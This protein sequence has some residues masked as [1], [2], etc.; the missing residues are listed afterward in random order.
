LSI[1][2]INPDGML[3]SPAFSQAIAVDPG[4]KLIFIGGQDGVDESGRVVADDLAGQTR[5]TLRNMRT[6]CETAGGKLEDIFK[7]TIF[8]VEGQDPRVGFGVFQE[9]WDR[10]APP[11]II[12]AAFV[13][14]LGVAG[15]LVEIEA[16][17]AVSA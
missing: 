1:E 3:K 14:S 9:E 4:M 5:Q 2:Y 10:S 6:I 16:V 11:P 13:S 12:T 15:A 8:V 7:W 17:A